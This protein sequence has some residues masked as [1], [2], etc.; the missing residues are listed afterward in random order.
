MTS[1]IRM[2]R[3]KA[4]VLR[5]SR[6]AKTQTDML[7]HVV[8][9]AVRPL[10]CSIPLR[11]KECRRLPCLHNRTTWY[12]RVLTIDF[13][14][15]RRRGVSIFRLRMRGR[16]RLAAPFHRSMSLTASASAAP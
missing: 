5:L 16:E 13:V 4:L 2:T 8:I 12:S 1:G 14:L 10:C 9:L 6:V 15:R 7:K 3:A 11:R